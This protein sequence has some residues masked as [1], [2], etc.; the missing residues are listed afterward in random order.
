MGNHVRHFQ[1]NPKQ[2]QMLT[3]TKRNVAYGGARGGGKSWVVDFK[4]GL[5]GRRYGRPDEWSAGIKMCLI[6]R[7]L[8]DLEKNHLNQL[9]MLLKNLAKYN[10]ND[11]MFTFKNGAET[12][13]DQEDCRQLPR[14]QQLSAQGVLHV[15][16]RRTGACVHQAAVRR[17]GV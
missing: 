12:G 6:R 15:Q 11:K 17:P 5:L 3:C 14:Y 9:K 8:K 10:A 7:T 4:I 2:W 13:M 16:P 1:P